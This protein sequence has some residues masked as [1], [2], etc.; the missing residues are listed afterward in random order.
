MKAIVWNPSGVLTNQVP[1]L[2]EAV[3]A[4]EALDRREEGWTKVELIPAAA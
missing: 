1:P 3:A 2:T 4:Y